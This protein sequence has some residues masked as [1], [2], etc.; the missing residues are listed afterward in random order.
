MTDTPYN[1]TWTT[2]VHTY[3]YL[4]LWQIICLKAKDEKCERKDKKEMKK[5]GL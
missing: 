1:G 2:Y 5:K 3:T 4:L